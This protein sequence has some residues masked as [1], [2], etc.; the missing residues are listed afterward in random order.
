MGYEH[1]HIH[2]GLLFR[3]VELRHQTRQDGLAL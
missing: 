1:F 2:Q 3:R